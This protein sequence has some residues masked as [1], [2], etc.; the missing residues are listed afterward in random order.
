MLVDTHA[1]L[2]YEYELTVPDLIS[3]AQGLGVDR[4]IAIA[5]APESLDRVR[6]LSELHKEV[7]FTSGIHPHEA[8]D[9]TNDLM[10]QIQVLSAHPRCLAIGELGLDYF[11]EHS[12]K[13]FQIAALEAQ[14]SF[15][16]QIGK[17]IVF[18]TRQADEDTVAILTPHAAAFKARWPD[19]VPGVIHCFSGGEELAKSCLAAGYYLSFSGI[20]T[21]KNAERLRMVVKDIC[22]MDRIL[23]ET[24][25]PYLA[26]MPHRGKKNHPAYTRFVAEKVA[27]LKGLSLDEV[28]R[29]TTENAERLFQISF[30]K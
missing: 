15:A 20:I 11:Y 4:I 2:D 3:E 13:E 14:L 9:W 21:F 12:G 28:A 18:H 5:A 26:P 25:S 7:Y 17:P 29:A 27:Q 10:S 8:K 6:A 23:V 19:R 16:L 24:D 22:P 1:H 30:A